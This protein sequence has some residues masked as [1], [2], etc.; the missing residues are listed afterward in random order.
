LVPFRASASLT[1]CVSALTYDWDFG[2][3]SPH[4]SVTNVCH[5]Y[6]V[7]GD[8]AWTLKVTANGVTQ[9][10][11]G[12][13]TISPTLGPPLNLTI[14]SYGFMMVLSWPADNIPVSVETS[15]DLSQPD[16]WI[17][18]FDAPMFDGINMTLWE[19]VLSDQQYFRLRRV[20]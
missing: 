1:Q 6:A 5:T 8:Y 9:S 18:L 11:N 15:M 14:T 3:G 12:L 13:V 10:V 17:Q 7:A 4:A 2:D 16:S 20:P 19:F